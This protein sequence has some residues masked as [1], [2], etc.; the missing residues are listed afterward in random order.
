[1]AQ[2]WAEMFP[3]MSDSEHLAAR[4]GEVLHSRADISRAREKLGCR[5]GVNF[6]DGLRLLASA[7]H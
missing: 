1:M 5:V 6:A 4:S 2:V 7:H 3:S